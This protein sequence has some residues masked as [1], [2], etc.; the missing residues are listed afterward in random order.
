ML[1]SAAEVGAAELAAV[2]ELLLLSVL[3][4]PCVS[5]TPRVQALLPEL[6]E[7]FKGQSYKTFQALGRCKIK[8]L[9]C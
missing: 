8:C 9:N 3:V 6:S 4:H 2:L 5:L 1:C 7:L